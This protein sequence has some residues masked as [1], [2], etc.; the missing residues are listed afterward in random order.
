M[1]TLSVVLFFLF[2]STPTAFAC[3]GE[4]VILTLPNGQMVQLEG[5]RDTEVQGFKILFLGKYK[6][7]IVSPKGETWEIG[8]PIVKGLGS[9]ESFASPPKKIEI[10]KI[11]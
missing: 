8:I 4:S 1:K 5:R 7:I 2:F 10:N 9:C 11:D 3:L 6:G